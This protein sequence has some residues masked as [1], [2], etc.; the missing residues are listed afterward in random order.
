MRTYINKNTAILMK[1][2]ENKIYSDILYTAP[3][4]TPTPKLPRVKKSS[5]T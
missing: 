4:S 1:D 3:A 5:P 2:F